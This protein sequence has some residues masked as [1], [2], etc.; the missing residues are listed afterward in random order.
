MSEGIPEF[1]FF[2]GEIVP[3]HAAKIHVWSET[4]IRATNVFEG[5]RAYWNDE[6]GA[7][8]LVAWPEHMARLQQSARLMRIP[9]PY[10]TAM[11]DE[12]V[13]RLLRKLAYRTHVYLRPTI[14]VEEGRYDYRA[15]NMKVGCYVAAF[16]VPRSGQLK[17]CRCMV[18]SWQRFSDLRGL[19]PGSIARP[20]TTTSAPLRSTSCG[21]TRRWYSR[22]RDFLSVGRTR[23]HWGSRCWLPLTGR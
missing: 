14:Y 9:H 1:I 18:S 22:T 2:N 3:W 6:R 7:W 19:P 15:E 5:A 4:A 13:A 10:T 11:L 23:S 12:G 16:P 20:H 21:Q 17:P 8:N